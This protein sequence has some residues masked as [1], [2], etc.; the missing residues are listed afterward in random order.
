MNITYQAKKIE[1]YVQKYWKEKKTFKVYENPEKIKYYCLVMLPYPSGSLHMGHIRNYTI[2]DVISRYQR[3][4]GKNVLHPIGWDA[5]GLP[6]EI[7]AIKNNT[8]PMEWTYKNIKSMKK[9]LKKMGFSYDW[10][11]E[12]TTCKPDYYKWEQW[13]FTEIVKKKL[14]YKKID[15]VN[16]CPTDKTVL[17]NEQ[18][19]DG[20]CW[21]CQTRVIKKNIPQWFIKI[22]KYAEELLKDLKNLKFW[23]EKVKN[24]QKNWIGKT[25]N[26]EIKLKVK[27]LN[28]IFTAYIK[29]LE[30]IMGATFIIMST[31]HKLT[32]F[33]SKVDSSIK[34]FINDNKNFFDK[35][36]FFFMKGKKTNLTAIHP[37]NKKKIPIWISNYVKNK[38]NEKSFYIGIPAHNKKDWTFSKFNQIKPKFVLLNLNGCKPNFGDVSIL[39]KGYLFNSNKFTGLSIKKGF[40]IIFNFLKNQKIAKKLISYKLKDWGISRQRYWGTPIPIAI[41]KENKNICIPKELLPLIL[42]KK[43]SISSRSIIINK[44][45]NVCETDTFDT[46][47]ESSWYY[48]RYTCPKFKQEMINFDAAKY[49]LPVDQYVGGIEHATMHLLYFRFYHK[50][51]RDFKLVPYNEPV[52]RLLCQGMVLSDAFYFFNEKKEKIWIS[53]NEINISRDKKGKII[54]AY[55]KNKIKAFHAGMIKMSKSK[56]NGID[57]ESVIKNYGVDTLRLFIMFSAPPEISIEW[58][59]SSIKG[60]SRFIHKLW[61]FCLKNIKNKDSIKKIKVQNLNFCQQSFYISLNKT[62]KK[63]TENIDERQTF[64]NAIAAIIKFTKKIINFPIKEPEDKYLVRFALINII[65]MLYPFIPHFSFVILERITSRKKIDF[66]KWP[67]F[68]KNFLEKTIFQI[69]IQINGKKK[70]TLNFL[71]NESKKNVISKILK[72]NIIENF[73]KE[74]KIKKIFFIPNK[75]IN[76]V[77]K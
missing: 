26:I 65:K 60:M 14:A 77:V 19:I 7:A 41:T 39:K 5:F 9:Q 61:K 70:K 32:K 48:A 73:L 63:V 40:N 11:R 27:N 31:E 34:N 33:L 23:P 42:P 17:A 29:N 18:V 56:N 43:N 21:R 22:T 71:K 59:P 55:T 51:L 45:K 52:I 49:W 47:I 67:T 44:K 58:N 54:Q 10:D 28:T 66:V 8:H 75:I 38:N 64:N 6:A 57:P 76:F 72:K 36:N 50:M 53:P 30:C 12:L 24:M 2:G 62:I 15:L 74:K 16:W 20:L 1:K 35:E 37:I 3:M 4:L 46:F 69:V 13:F 25:I 68:D